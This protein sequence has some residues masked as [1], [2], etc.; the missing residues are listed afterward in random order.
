LAGEAGAKAAPPSGGSG[1]TW[2]FV[3]LLMMFIVLSPGVRNALGAGM[4][5]VMDPLV[6]FGGVYP[7]WSIL[8]GSL[9]I[10]VI[11]QVI[12]HLMTDWVHLAK[13]QRYMT[14]FNKELTEARKSGNAQ[15]M[16]KLMEM[17]PQVMMR[18]MDVQAQT[19][20][21]TVFTMVV[22]V[23]FITWIYVFT[24][25]AVVRTISLPWE[26][27]WP[28]LA[29]AWMPYSVVLYMLFSIV[30]GQVVINTLKYMSFSRRLR[31]LDAGAAEADEHGEASG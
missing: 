4:A 9:V 10:V 27:A 6:G 25:S 14:A 15:R 2:M 28:L 30:L 22:F 8:L 29:T 26:D 7:L 23:A 19:M 1:M 13:D 17:Q 16:Q 31:A 20:K 18:Q 12:R 5:Y 3:M 24:A 11:S 21:P